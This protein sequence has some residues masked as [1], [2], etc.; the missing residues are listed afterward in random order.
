MSNEMAEIKFTYPPLSEQNEIAEYLD[1]HIGQINKAIEPYSKMIAL[2]QERKQII[3]S[4]VVT[5]K[6]KV[7]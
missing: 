7:S 4:E 2:L 6:I 3:I 1:K 5:G